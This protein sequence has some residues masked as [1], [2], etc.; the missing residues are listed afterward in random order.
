MYAEFYMAYIK[1]VRSIC[2]KCTYS[3]W[4]CDDELSLQRDKSLAACT[5]SPCSWFWLFFWGIN[6][7]LVNTA[8]RFQCLWCSDRSTCIEMLLQ[9]M[10]AHTQESVVTLCRV[11]LSQVCFI[12]HKLPLSV[13]LVIVMDTSARAL[14]PI[15]P[16]GVCYLLF[17]R[18]QW[19]LGGGGCSIVKQL[20]RSAPHAVTVVYVEIHPWNAQL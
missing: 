5:P 13:S 15:A 10:T 9:I 2:I 16:D 20:A 4:E 17:I 8:S 7:S 6:T 1:I 11:H 14:L 3:I 18:Q 12:T 19:E